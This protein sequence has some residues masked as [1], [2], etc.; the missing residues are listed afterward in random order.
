MVQEKFRSGYVAIV[1][2]PNVGKSTLLNAFLNF[3][4]SI[5]TPKPQ[6]TRKKILGILNGENHQIIF[7][8]TPGWISPTYELQKLMMHYVQESLLDADV[9]ILMVEVSDQPQD[10]E[11]IYQKLFSLS[12]KIILVMN[13]IDKIFKDK[14]LPLIDEYQKKYLF[15]S[16]VPISAL[17][18]DGIQRLLKE[19]LKY[20]PVHPP[21]FPLDYTSDQTER[22][23][24]TEIIREKI[25]QEY[26]KEIPYACHVELEEFKEQPGRK[27][28]I[29][30]IIYVDH[31]SQK[32]II[33]GKSGQALK[34]IG[35][36]ARKDIETFLGREVYLELFVRVMPNW[37][38]KSSSLKKLGY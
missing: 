25:F 3:K 30:A 27:D 23:F 16:C 38:K 11:P 18:Q 13:K 32:G 31:D 4:L 1:G 7:I 29:R 34:K 10:I 24:V 37:R 21:Y 15:E 33:I 35:E 6:T 14:L 19:I 22:F 28:L 26:A 2:K 17:Q 9:I 20:L 12:K 5:V 8:D 36:L